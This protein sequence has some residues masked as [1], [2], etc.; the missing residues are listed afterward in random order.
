MADLIRD[1]IQIQTADLQVPTVRVCHF[2]YPYLTRPVALALPNLYSC[3][4]PRTRTQWG[5]NP[6]N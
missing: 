1:S 5:C 4:C 2:G 3:H 6:K